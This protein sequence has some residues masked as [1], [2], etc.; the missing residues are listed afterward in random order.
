VVGLGFPTDEKDEDSNEWRVLIAGVRRRGL[1]YVV[2]PNDD[3]E[4]VGTDCIY[5]V[6]GTNSVDDGNSAIIDGLLYGEVPAIEMGVRVV[7]E[8]E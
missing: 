1:A 7:E 6:G 8:E 5:P 4:C 2:F 3:G